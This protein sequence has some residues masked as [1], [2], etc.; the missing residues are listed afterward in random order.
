MRAFLVETRF[1]S[2]RICCTDMTRRHLTLNAAAEGTPSVPQDAHSPGHAGLGTSIMIRTITGN[3]VRCL[4]TA[5]GLSI[6]LVVLFHT[7]IT[8]DHLEALSPEVW[9]IS[10]F[11]SSIRMPVFF[12][13]SGLLGA[14]VLALSWRT[15]LK[16]RVITL[17]YLYAL[18]GAID[19]ATASQLGATT[20][21]N[22]W[23]RSF[24][25]P[26]PIL[27]FI[28]ALSAYFVIAKLC[29]HLKW[30]ALIFSAS[31]TVT[32]E[33]NL[34]TETTEHQ[35]SLAYATFFLA[36]A[37]MGP[38]VLTA[39]KFWK[40][41][42]IAS[43]PLYAGIF[44]AARWSYIAQEWQALLPAL[45]I[46]AGLSGARLLDA[47]PI[48][49]SALIYLGR[50]TLAIYLAHTQFLKL[51]KANSA[52]L[53]AWPDFQYWGIFITVAAS[54]GLSLALRSIAESVGWRWLY[55]L[56]SFLQ[57]QTSQIAE[58]RIKE[59]LVPP[60]ADNEC[61]PTVQLAG[62]STPSVLGETLGP[63]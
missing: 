31:L 60:S 49:N 33:L 6:F 2:Q 51:L 14:R 4:D 5:R 63:R 62:H 36:G 46:V 56:P 39:V 23:L 12:T 37:Y 26:N 45:G 20:G 54:I 29:R 16:K 15:F 43:L 40:L 57:K 21:V 32:V 44:F 41:A 58:P 11:F 61:R 27:W 48:L 18:W 13:I 25:A 34:L 38:T 8:L 10:D 22:D 59:G 3:R 17:L 7:S 55:S 9:L 19:L 35:K 47:V 52:T 1:I 28:W 30:P 53:A 24:S 50:N 42:L